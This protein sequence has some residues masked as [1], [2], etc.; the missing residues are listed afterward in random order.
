VAPYDTVE[1]ADVTSGARRRGLDA[2]RGL[3]AFA[4]LIHHVLLANPSLADAYLSHPQLPMG[5][6]LLTYSPLHLVWAGGEAVLVFFVLSG[7]ALTAGFVGDRRP[8]WVNYY[9]RR[10]VRLYLPV[11][12]AIAV[13]LP[14]AHWLRPALPDPDASWVY[15]AQV[16]VGTVHNALRDVTLWHEKATFL[17]GPLWSLHW[18]VLF[19]LALP[20]YLLLTRVRLRIA[21]LAAGVGLLVLTG[22]GSYHHEDSLLFL[23]IFG[24]GVLVATHEGDLRALARRWSWAL[25]AVGCL[26]VTAHWS[27][28]G[29][30]DLTLTT[31]ATTDVLTVIGATLI[32]IAFLDGI[33]GT[34]AAR[35]RVVQWLGRRSFSLYLVHAPLI[36]TVGY[37]LGGSPSTWLLLALCVPFSLLAAEVFGRYV[38][39]PSH[40]LS[41]RIGRAADARFRR[42]PVSARKPAS[43]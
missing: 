26:L 31:R 36:T 32:V 3:A 6:K 34:W 12:A 13:A 22:I 5:T 11:V 21:A 29:V 2:L 8:S 30:K 37:L 24:L 28:T 10:V 14:Q 7:F 15:N 17:D 25:V 4:V 42:E 18:E 27:V 16:H 35:D 39:E 23:P 41:Q 19:S 40:R 9:P 20:A 1:P 38:E 33:V 43:S